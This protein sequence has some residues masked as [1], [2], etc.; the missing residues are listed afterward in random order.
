MH[1]IKLVLIVA[2]HRG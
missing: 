1:T 2:N